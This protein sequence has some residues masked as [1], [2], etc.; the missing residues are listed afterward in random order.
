MAFTEIAYD[1]T[2]R[3]ATITLNRPEKR[4]AWSAETEREVRDAFA[5]AARDDEVRA[6]ILTG[7]GRSFCVG[8]DV[9]GIAG[10]GTERPR[11]AGVTPPPGEPPPVEDLARRYS[12]ILN[13]GKPVI[14][15]INGAVAGV[16]L[17]V[18]LYCD[19]RFMVAGARLACAF[20]R[21][22]L[23]AEHGSAWMLPRLIGPMNAAD[24]LLSGR[25][26]TAEEAAAMGL[27]RVLPEDGFAAA[28]RAYATD[29]VENCSPRSLRVIKR[30]L[31]LAPLQSLSAAIALAEAEQAATIGT[32]DRREGAAAFLEKRKPAFTGR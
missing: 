18:T 15:A 26:I 1:V 6:I 30:Q 5:L 19:L 17:A 9:S 23:I 28:V 21:R 25:T 3:I 24:L 31:V 32:E 10:R 2:G 14:A 29:L 12:Y 11:F 22:G 20:P 7:A 27:V 4:N 16:G 8:A 13:I